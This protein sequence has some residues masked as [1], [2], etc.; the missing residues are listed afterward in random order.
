M[1]GLEPVASRIR[2]GIVIE[3][4][5]LKTGLSGVRHNMIEQIAHEHKT[6]GRE[7]GNFAHLKPKKDVRKFSFPVVAPLLWDAVSMET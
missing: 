1:C 4:F 7:A 5:K 2:R 6:R 3:T